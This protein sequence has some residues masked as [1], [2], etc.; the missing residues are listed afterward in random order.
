MCGWR[1]LVDFTCESVGGLTVVDSLFSGGSVIRGL[2]YG[3]MGRVA[4]E[5]WQLS[6]QPL[7]L[8]KLTYTK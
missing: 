4:P 1:D 3:A 8:L 5:P 7:E 2:A 6:L